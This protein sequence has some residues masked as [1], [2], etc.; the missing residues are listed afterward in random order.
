ML[1]GL[2]RAWQ[3]RIGQ[4]K[5]RSATIEEYS[6]GASNKFVSEAAIFIMRIVMFISFAILFAVL[7]GYTYFSTYPSAQ[8]VST[9]CL[10]LT[11]VALILVGYS[12]L[13]SRS[14]FEDIRTE[15]QSYKERVESDL[16]KLGTSISEILQSAEA[17]QNAE[18][19][20]KELAVDNADAESQ[21]PPSS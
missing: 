16:K 20:A 17:Q 21:T 11:A 6:E 3:R 14:F 4:I 18:Q 19:S 12:Y 8:L 5:L 15:G 2:K 1:F 13:S 7:G 10:S 9:I